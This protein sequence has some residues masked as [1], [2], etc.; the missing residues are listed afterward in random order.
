MTDLAE[1]SD[2]EARCVN[3][4]SSQQQTRAIALI[5]DASNWVKAY[6]RRDFVHE[7]TE[8]TLRCTGDLLRLPNTPVISVDAISLRDPFGNLYPMPIYGFDGI[9]RINIGAYFGL[10][11]NGPD[12]MDLQGGTWPYTAQVA[13]T[14]GYSA[15]PSDLVGVVATAVA[16]I[17]NSPTGGLPGATSQSAG[18]FHTTIAPQF[19]SGSPTFTSDDMVIIK[20]YRRRSITSVEI[21]G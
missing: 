8:E 13:Y 7:Q 16:R 15:I 10:V 9:D 1:L 11:A 6:C 17:F 4:L 14:H 18:P 12:I 3:T 5:T 2:V 20:K 21:R 19:V